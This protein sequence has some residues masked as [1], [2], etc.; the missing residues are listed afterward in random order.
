VKGVGIDRGA[1]R[2]GEPAALEEDEE[3]DADAATFAE[4]VEDA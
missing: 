4:V 1:S 3:A 2:G